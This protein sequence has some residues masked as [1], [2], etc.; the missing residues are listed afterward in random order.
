MHPSSSSRN[1]RID[2][3]R[4]IAISCVLIL[5]FALAYGLKD[6]PLGTLLG[7]TLL[8]AIAFNGNYGVTI[9]FVISGYLITSHSLARWGELRHVDAHAFYRM[10]FARIMPPLLLALAIIV[11]LGCFD[12]PFFSNGDGGHHRPASFFL[13]GAGSVLTFWHNVLMQSAGYFNYCLN[14]YWSLSVE[15]VFYL[16]LPLACLALRRE[17][18]IVALCAIAIVAGPLY[19]AAHANNEIF[20]MYGYAACFDAIAIGC[21]TALLA[22]R[23]APGAGYRRLLRV[24]SLMALAAVYLR[25][26]DGNEALGFTLIAL[27]SAGFLLASA[28]DGSAGWT[29]GRAT[30]ALRWMGRHS[31]EIYLFH[32]IVLAAMRNVLA[33]AAMSHDLRLPWLALFLALTMIV[34]GLVARFVSEPANAALRGRR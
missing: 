33:K 10:R 19:R 4:G 14:V 29:A 24:L 22:R 13:I 32:I 7:P 1:A 6:S 21:L 3:L 18:M 17:A 5:H 30:F 11:T 2:F 28:N 8:R 16:L 27:A 34:A 9:F 31:Y 26:I 20:F 12:V 15:E 25:G 23:L